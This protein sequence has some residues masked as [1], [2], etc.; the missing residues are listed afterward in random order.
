[1]ILQFGKHK[2]KSITEVPASYL[3]YL[4]GWDKLKPEMRTAIEAVKAG[5]YNDPVRWESAPVRP[6]YEPPDIHDRIMKATRTGAR[7]V[8]HDV[9]QAVEGLDIPNV[10]KSKVMEMLLAVA[11]R[12]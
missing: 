1:M 2:G 8:L 5:T 10:H 4:L 7:R 9:G 6:A 12:I 11:G 3:D